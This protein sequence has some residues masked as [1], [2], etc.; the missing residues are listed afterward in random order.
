MIHK[1]RSLAAA[2]LIGTLQTVSAL[3]NGGF[4]ASPFS[5]GWNVTGA[6]AAGPGLVAGSVQSARFTSSGQALAQTVA[7]GADWHVDAYVAVK[8]SAARQLSL[9]IYNGAN[10]I[11]NLRYEAGAWA[12]YNATAF[13]SEP[14][15]GSLAA[16][17]DANNDGDLDDAGD[18]KNV[19][20]LRLTGRGFGTAA[21]AYD[22]SV[23]DANG[24]TFTR[25]VTGRT[26]WQNVSGTAATPLSI[27]F[28]SEFGN[29][30]GWWLDEVTQHDDGPPPGPVTLPYVENF[31]TGTHRFT[32]GAD[33]AVIGGAYR[34]TITATTATG[35]ASLFTGQLGGPAET[36][37]GFLL[38]SKFTLVTNSG[39]GNTVG[40]GIMGTNATFTGGLAMPYYLVELRPAASTLRCLRVGIN[41]TSFLPE[42]A[43]QTMTLNPALPFTLEVRGTYEHGALKMDLTVRQGASSETFYVVDTVPL[44]VGHFGYRNRTNGGALTVD[45]DDFTLRRLSTISITG[46]PQPFARPGEAYSAPVAAVSNAGSAVTLTAPVLP[47]WLTF[48]PGP[49]GTGTLS[50]TPSAAQT[51]AHTVRLSAS[52]PDTGHTEREFSV[53]VLAAQGVI[54]SE[55]LAENDAGL[56]DEDGDQPDWVELFNTTT[57]PVNIGGWWLSDDPLVPMKWAIPAGASIPAGGFLTI[58]ASAKNRTSL[59]LHT[60]FRLS[61]AA[62][63]HVSL[64]MTDGTL[65]ST[66]SNYPAQRADHSY[67]AHGGYT[68]HGYLLAP[69][70]GAP[71][72]ATAYNGFVA[73]TDFLVGRGYYTAPVAETVTCT[74][75]GAVIVY[76]TDGSTPSL[77]KGTQSA[78]PL[79]LTISSTT[80][81]RVGAFAPGL[82][83]SGPDTQSYFFSSDIRT[84][85]STGAPPAG[86]PQGPVNGQILDYGMDPDITGT[87]TPQQMTDALRALPALSLTTDLPNLFDNERG[88][89]VNPYG[90]EEGYEVPVS[91]ELLQP[92]NTPGFHINAGLRIRGGA[93][94]EGTVPKHNFHLYFRGEYGAA[95]LNYPLFG[96]EG[97][98]TF[99]RIDLRTAQVM[100]WGKDGSTAATY[101]RDE[102]NRLTHGAMG[103]PYTRSRYYHL[104]I[105]GHYWGLYGTQER[106][107]AAYAATY[108]GGRKEDYDVMKTFVIPHRVEAADGDNAA[109]SQLFTAASAGFAGNTAYY[110]VQG[111]GADGLPNGTPPLLD[112]DSLIDYTLLRY[113]AADDDAPVNPGVGVPKNF[114]ALRPRDGRF[115]FQFL[116]HDAESCMRSTAATADFTGNITTGNTLSYFNPRWLSQQLAG[117]AKYRLR[118]A[119]RAQR[120]LFNGGALD[121]AAAIARWRALAAEIAPAMLA[122]SARWGD[123]KS[124]TPRTVAQWQAA[125]NAVETGF[126]A[127]RRAT[128]IGQLR[129]R[130]LFPSLNAPAFSQHGGI[131]PAGFTLSISAP[132]GST[133]FYTLDQ[134]DPADPAALAYSG[135]ITLSGSQTTVKARAKLTAT[136]EWSALTEALF[137]LNAIPAAAGN[138][139]ISE[140]HYNPPGSGDDT[141]FVELINLSTSRVDL[142]GAR[143]TGGMIFTFGPIILEPGARLCLV[144]NEAAFRGAYGPSAVIAGQW[145]GALNNGGDTLTLLSAADVEIETVSYGDALPWPPAADGDG[146]SL[147]RINPLTPPVAENWRPSVAAGGNPGTVDGDSFTAWLAARGLTATADPDANGLAAIM[148]FALGTDL[149]GHSQ[150]V[151]T[152]TGST[153]TWRQ[154]IAGTGVTLT[155]ETSENLAAWESLTTAVTARVFHGDGTESITMSLPEGSARRYVRLRASPVN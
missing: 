85:S 114:Y 68:A 98:D 131:V 129:T 77:T 39:T 66:Y 132:A 141:E 10:A 36:A 6:P 123:A 153:F 136:G 35:I 148:E 11:V 127:T 15:L 134:S 138:V 57:A 84:Q 44:E 31:G 45:C 23:S 65:V 37:T 4:E 33:W 105:N 21:A 121:N 55:F 28:G 1:S 43:L 89:Y 3:T 67:G 115:G 83:P 146:P 80:V 103:Q 8:A 133:I 52:D 147:V 34:N 109:W 135:A 116:T 53:C 30:P 22:L 150:P 26:R 54:I 104:Y 69:T 71:N 38:S 113:Y 62:G 79:A 32:A 111:R 143:F 73:D 94:R 24:S 124:S 42:S 18:T 107:D 49:N 110:S 16:S 126:I 76:T 96:D 117:N 108:L 95:K 139:A 51:G 25:T 64:A 93:S 87:V 151:Q 99:D 46:A 50:G 154:R 59:P 74:T 82:A 14:A 41:S 106:A 112:V 100:G 48:T 9:I 118:F 155:A 27:K 61:N 142:S 2:L 120:H 137:T 97:A 130:G 86:W 29:N 60:N 5:T 20:R 140:I 13:I 101:M 125:V 88:I 63:G 47:S 102:W 40:F 17:V 56:K 145:S 144:E 92:D 90:R 7:W 122:E 128:L 78:S 70:P 119:D 81:L 72:E 91:L 58:F 149:S 75:P 12:A 19:Y 152:H